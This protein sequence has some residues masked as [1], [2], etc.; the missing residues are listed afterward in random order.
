MRSSKTPKSA[1]KLWLSDS[2]PFLEERFKNLSNEELTKKISEIWRTGLQPDV[3]K[4]Y[5]EKEKE[6][7]EKGTMSSNFSFWILAKL[8]ENGL[9]DERMSVKENW[10]YLKEETKNWYKEEFVKYRAN[11]V[12]NI[13]NCSTSTEF[14]VEHDDSENQFF[15]AENHQSGEFSENFE[16]IN[17]TCRTE[18]QYSFEDVS[19]QNADTKDPTSSTQPSESFVFEI[20]TPSYRSAVRRLQFQDSENLNSEDVPHGSG[21]QNQSRNL[22]IHQNNR[23]SKNQDS[24]KFQENLE[25][26]PQDSGIQNPNLR[27]SENQEFENF[28]ENF[29]HATQ[30]LGIQNQNLRK[31]ENQDF[32]SSEMY[33]EDVP[34]DSGLQNQNRKIQIPQNSRISK[35]QDSGNVQNFGNRR[36][37]E[38]QNPHNFR[39]QNQDFGN[40][41]DSEI[42]NQNL[43][44]SRN[45]NSGNLENQNPRNFRISKNQD[46]RCFE[47]DSDDVT[48]NSRLQNQNRNLQILQNSKN[49]KNQDSG[50]I[51]NFEN[52]RNS[53]G[54]KQNPPNS[55]SRDYGDSGNLENQNSRHFRNFRNQD[56]GNMQ[57]S[58]N[59]ENQNPRNFRISENQATRKI[60]VSR[61]R[62]ITGSLPQNQNSRNSGN[63]QKNQE[64]PLQNLNPLLQYGAGSASRLLIQ[65]SEETKKILKNLNSQNSGIQNFQKDFQTSRNSTRIQNQNQNSKIQNSRSFQKNSENQNFS[66]PQL[67]ENSRPEFSRNS[68][69]QNMTSSK[70]FQESSSQNLSGNRLNSTLGK[71]KYVLKIVDCRE[72][73]LKRSGKFENVILK[74]QFSPKNQMPDL[75]PYGEDQNWTQ[76]HNNLAEKLAENGP[77][78]FS[79]FN[80]LESSQ[81]SEDLFQEFFVVPESSGNLE[82]TENLVP[83]NFGNSENPENLVQ[84][85]FVAPPLENGQNDVEWDYG[86]PESPEF[87][88]EDVEIQNPES[89]KIPYKRKYEN[90]PV[91][92]PNEKIFFDLPDGPRWL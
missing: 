7:K 33:S 37:L 14:Q 89:P 42:Q 40:F 65:N 19:C 63:F 51:Q 5:L 39:I 45:Q 90:W 48:E 23:I 88:S 25:D 9:F 44:I 35:N 59:W 73:L 53:E 85:F 21:S 52:R 46:S 87:T 84:E 92:S 77:T 56:P 8:R 10:K 13:P 6:L 71:R 29:E 2:R 64:A 67:A 36:N 41:H 72:D 43:S 75:M 80:N 17:G 34:Q 58:G 16:T 4:S 57:K 1:F 27:I 66:E 49:S 26:V 30:D 18:S 81:D 79:E 11:P 70:N 20:P 12:E 69:F 50:T 22:Q 31:L 24:R 3:K 76:N 86:A 61:I 28:D 15:H 60:Q 82:N 54:R 55:R 83:D 91:L 62:P 74:N 68:E 32:R 47:M 78:D 38:N